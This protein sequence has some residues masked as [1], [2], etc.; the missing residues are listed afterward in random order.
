MCC[1][2]CTINS[3]AGKCCGGM[4]FCGNI[5]YRFRRFADTSLYFGN[6][7]GTVTA[8]KSYMFRKR[9]LIICVGTEKFRHRKKKRPR[10]KG[11][12]SFQ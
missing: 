1:F 10:L 8:K 7:I 3:I 6:I 2:S 4:T 9:K 11:A 12:G 5:R